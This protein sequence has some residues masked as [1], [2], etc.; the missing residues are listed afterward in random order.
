MNLTLK[1]YV[2]GLDFDVPYLP[3]IQGVNPEELPGYNVLL[4][5]AFLQ[6][7]FWGIN[8]NTKSAWLAQAPG[9][10]PKNTGLGSD[11]RDLTRDTKT[12][13]AGTGLFRDSWEGY[14]TP[15]P[16]PRSTTYS[17]DLSGGDIA[18]IVVGVVA[19]ILIV[20]ALSTFVVRRPRCRSRQETAR[21][22]Q[23]SEAENTEKRDDR[24]SLPPY[25]Q[26]HEVPPSDR[27]E[28]ANTSDPVELPDQGYIA[29]APD[30]PKQ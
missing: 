8:W 26:Y 5:R 30:T 7:A 24:S 27:F 23:L 19:F 14:W 29:E 13:D 17:N 16:T 11:P 21:K 9:P 2:S 4:G 3:I 12:L 20:A 15:M 28:M 1:A 10:G 22:S 25:P 18:G 6:A